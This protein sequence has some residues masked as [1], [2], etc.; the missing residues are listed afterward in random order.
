MTIFCNQTV[1]SE[2]EKK[3]LISQ[4]NNCSTEVQKLTPLLLKDLPSYANRVIQRTQ[5]IHRRENIRNYIISA[6]KAEFEPLKLPHLEYDRDQESSTEQVFFTVLERQ[7]INQKIT[8]IQTYHWLFLTP[9]D[10]GWR[11]VMM[12][13][14][15]DLEGNNNP[16]TPPQETTDGAIGQAIQIWLKDCRWGTLRH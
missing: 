11:M 2:T 10:R 14:R 16:P 7:Y 9:S 1:R 13:S 3:Y 5:K 12:F 4:T 6:G 15:Y 8:K